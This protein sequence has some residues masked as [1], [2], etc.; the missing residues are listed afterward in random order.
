LRALLR[1]KR[2]TTLGHLF[3]I[4]KNKGNRQ[5]NNLYF[6]VIAGKQ[7]FICDLSVEFLGIAREDRYLSESK[8]LQSKYFP[9]EESPAG[10]SLPINKSS[11]TKTS[12]TEN[13]QKLSK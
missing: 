10:K 6:T 8:L 9:D 2:T 4:L 7:L 11:R 1:S 13:I 12:P 5:I 3:I